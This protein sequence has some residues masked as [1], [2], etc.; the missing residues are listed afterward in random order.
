MEK[1]WSALALKRRE[2]CD[3]R[4]RAGKAKIMSLGRQTTSWA[5]TPIIASFLLNEPHF[6]AYHLAYNRFLLHICADV[7]RNLHSV[8]LQFRHIILD[9][10]LERASE[11]EW[12]VKIIGQQH[13]ELL[14][15]MEQCEELKIIII[16]II[17][18]WICVWPKHKTYIALKRWQA[19]R[20]QK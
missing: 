11:R 16:I 5:L 1:S 14:W 9:F 8:T 10:N 19:L 17:T 6:R 18:N 13:V 15:A 12:D 2:R 20:H 3:E 7:I 4:A